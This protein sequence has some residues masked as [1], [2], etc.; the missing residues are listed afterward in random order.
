M[1]KF[2]KDWKNVEKVVKTRNN[3]QLR[4][5]AQKFFYKLNNIDKE[6]KKCKNFNL[7][8]PTSLEMEILELFKE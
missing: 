8:R 2:G 1:V 5:H 4:S 7:I 6:R 3:S